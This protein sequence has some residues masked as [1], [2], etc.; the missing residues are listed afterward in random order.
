MSTLTMSDLAAPVRALRLLA[1]DF[2]DLPAVDF[3][4]S[5][6][7]PDLLELSCHDGFSVFE[8]WRE[9]LGIPLD[10]VTYTELPVSSTRVLEARIDYASV[11]L[12]LV[13]YSPAESQKAVA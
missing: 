6:V 9:A 8:A 7:F 2:P 3:G 13:G 10:S 5:R 12:R 11:H 4:I 1:A